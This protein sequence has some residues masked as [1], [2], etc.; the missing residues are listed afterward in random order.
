L[1]RLA[2]VIIVAVGPLHGR[3]RRD[4]RLPIIVAGPDSIPLSP[5]GHLLATTIG[6]AT[7][8]RLQTTSRLHA[9]LTVLD[10]SIARLLFLDLALALALR[11]VEFI[12]LGTAAA[13]IGVVVTIPATIWCCP[14][15]SAP[16]A[17][18]SLLLSRTAFIV[19]SAPSKLVRYVV[20]KGQTGAGCGRGG[21]GGLL[22]LLLLPCLPPGGEYAGD[23]LLLPP[24]AALLPRQR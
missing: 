3:K 19:S 1:I 20:G 24:G 13:W 10:I 12:L 11:R 18:A 17:A 22:L 16:T 8:R 2:V 5:L 15:A 14:V 6:A 9:V 23:D 7:G 4:R 21:G